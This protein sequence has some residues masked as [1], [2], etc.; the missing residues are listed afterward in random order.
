MFLPYLTSTPGYFV[1][2][3]LSENAK[4]LSDRKKKY[5][6]LQPQPPPPLSSSSS[7]VISLFSL[8]VWCACCANQTQLILRTN[9]CQQVLACV[10]SLMVLMSFHSLYNVLRV[11]VYLY[12]KKA[13]AWFLMSMEDFLV[14]SCLLIILLRTINDDT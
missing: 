8:V 11:Y 14:V 5:I 13:D 10:Q 1:V 3:L 9:T 4:R 2:V 12:K 6:N 7:F